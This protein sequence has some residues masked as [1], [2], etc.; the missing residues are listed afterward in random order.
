MKLSNPRIGNT[1]NI[2]VTVYVKLLNVLDRDPMLKTEHIHTVY[3]NIVDLLT[4]FDL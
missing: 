4:N 1:I 3:V 2:H